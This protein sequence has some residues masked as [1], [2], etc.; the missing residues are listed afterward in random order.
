MKIL[1][2]MIDVVMPEEPS[3]RVLDTLSMYGIGGRGRSA[4][5]V[6]HI[7]RQAIIDDILTE[8]IGNGGKDV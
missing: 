8:E 3:S 6:Y 5:E 4:E 7:I 1:E 2:E